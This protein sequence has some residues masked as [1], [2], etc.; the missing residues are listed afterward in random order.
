MRTAI[1]CICLI[2]AQFVYGQ[3]LN[4]VINDML[5]RVYEECIHTN[6]SIYIL[7]NVDDIDICYKGVNPIKIGYPNTPDSLISYGIFTIQRIKKKKNTLLIQISSY[8][9]YFKN[10]N[11]MFCLAGGSDFYYKREKGCYIFDK[12]KDWGI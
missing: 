12:K 1:V 3:N 9:L 2:S 8:G 10:G 7:N 5:D 4:Y 6:D 11:K